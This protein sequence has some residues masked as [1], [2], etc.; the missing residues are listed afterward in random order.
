MRQ[1]AS[2][3]YRPKM[4]NPQKE[5]GY[6]PISNELLEA[7]VKSH[8]L[9]AEYQVVFFVIR[10]TYGYN[11]KIDY[12]SLTQFEIGTELSRPTIIKS[13]KNL[14]AKNILVSNK[15]S[16]FS[17]NKDYDK[18]GSKSVF[19][20]KGV[21][22]TT[23]KSVFT[24][25]SKS[26]FTHKRQLNTKDNY[27]SK[28]KILSTNIKKPMRKNSFKYSE[29]NHDD[30]FEDVVNYDTTGEVVKSK[31]KVSKNKT[32]VKLI[33]IF[34]K[35]VE[36]KF[37]IKRTSI[38]GEYFTILNAMKEFSGE[39]IINIFDE[40]LSTPQEPEVLVHLNRALSNTQLNNYKIKNRG[41]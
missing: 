19:T 12:I 5:D 31:P 40:W 15:P 13:L 9:G 26:V 39:E 7:I 33:E 22:T 4:A 25:G 30:Y 20:S 29:N 36:E 11:K 23:S 28:E 41:N 34:G 21:F 38:K 32:A 24:E 37:N 17:I 3:E 6:V 14:I 8:L 10:K 2:R 35:M 1:T 16:H 27:F 18:W